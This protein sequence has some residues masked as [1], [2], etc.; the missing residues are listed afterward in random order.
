M[1]Q[2]DLTT[3]AICEDEF[4]AVQQRIN[5]KLQKGPSGRT[6]RIPQVHTKTD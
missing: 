6:Y 2:V 3:V 4:E 1:T 5:Q